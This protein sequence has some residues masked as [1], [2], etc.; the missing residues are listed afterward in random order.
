[1]PGTVTIP[2]YHAQFVSSTPMICINLKIAAINGNSIIS[3]HKRFELL[4][5]TTKFSHDLILI[6]ETKLNDKHKLEFEFF[7]LI[8]TDR[9]G[10]S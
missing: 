9:P 8:R 7:N 2:S 10:S 4:E 1:M 3:N 6:S 5:F